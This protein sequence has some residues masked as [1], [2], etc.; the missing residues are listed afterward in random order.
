MEW[1]QGVPFCSLGFFFSLAKT[2]FFKVY[3]FI[4]FE[5]ER[6]RIL[7]RLHAPALSERWGLISRQP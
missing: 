5:R 1:V 6:E 3:L 2:S 7:S 4:Y